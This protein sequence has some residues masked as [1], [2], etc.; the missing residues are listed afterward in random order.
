MSDSSDSGGRLVRRQDGRLAAGVCTGIARYFGWDV[1]LVRLAFGV[2]T[3][4]YGLGVLLYA[5]A[6]LVLPAEGG[7]SILGSFL[8]GHRP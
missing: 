8:H 6:W 3:I 7:G 5:L 2:F 1:N 4:F